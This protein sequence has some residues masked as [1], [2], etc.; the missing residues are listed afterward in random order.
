[1]GKSEG[2]VEQCADLQVK[3]G[4]VH[5]KHGHQYDLK[6]NDPAHLL[7]KVAHFAINDETFFYKPFLRENNYRIKVVT[8]IMVG[9]HVQ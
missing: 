3:Y 2:L 5:V 8:R 7:Y 6:K 4:F 9:L 1:M